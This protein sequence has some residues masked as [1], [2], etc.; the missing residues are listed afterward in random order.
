[1]NDLRRWARCDLD[2]GVDWSDVEEE[3]LEAIES[4]DV[5][6]AVSFAIWFGSAHARL[7][8]TVEEL[9]A[10]HARDDRS[11]VRRWAGGGK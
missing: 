2:V 7:A 4:D 1:M 10:Q 5:Y 8:R 9:R 6:A 3:V 11:L